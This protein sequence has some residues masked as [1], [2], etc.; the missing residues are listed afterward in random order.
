MYFFLIYH[1]TWII[2]C[3]FYSLASFNQLQSKYHLLVVDKTHP[4]N[5]SN[6]KYHFN[7]EVIALYSSFTAQEHY[8]L[9]ILQY[10]RQYCYESLRQLHRGLLH[11]SKYFKNSLFKYVV[12]LF[13]EREINVL[14]TVLECGRGQVR[15]QMVNS[16]EIQYVSFWLWGTLARFLKIQSLLLPSSPV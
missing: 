16:S 4:H 9:P 7:V 10:C 6:T 5:L 13:A 1:M 12:S 14:Q 15:E 2:S 8:K 3:S 11:K